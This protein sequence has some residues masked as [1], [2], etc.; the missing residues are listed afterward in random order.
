MTILV[1]S[2]SA[3]EQIAGQCKEIAALITRHTESKG[4]GFHQ[5][6]IDK[7][8]FARESCVAS[9]LAAVSSPMLAIVVQGKKAAL[10]GED[11]YYYGSAQ[12]L[13][14]S[15][16]LPISGFIT[17][18]TSTQPYLG[19]KLDLD[20]RQ[21][22]EIMTA[23]P[24]IIASKKETSIR[25]FFV[26]TAEAPLLDCALRLTKLLDTPQDIPM[27]APMITQEIYYRLLMGEQCEAVRQIA[28]SGSN[29]QR[30][31]QAIQH[32]KTNFTRP[33]RIEDLAD[34]ANMS[35]SS[36]H[37]HFKQVTSI[38]PL[39]YQK[40]LKLIEARRLMLVER[41]TA[42]NAADR[43]GYESPS[44]FSREYARMFGAPPIRDI[45]VAAI[46]Q[47]RRLRERSR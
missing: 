34:R 3:N 6:S 22:G 39:Q 24:S 29:M 5:T 43:V 12:Y 7:L 13:I 15:V 10:L 47:S 31:A 35:P 16:D 32:I 23:Q 38:S 1:P 37:Y 19:F 17:E 30:I 8:Q 40:Q 18:A 42:A 2:D 46:R 44:Q 9:T 41:S 21:L 36:F 45:G 28:T 26:S 20:P 11:T 14:L 4:D 25:G 33:L 27:L